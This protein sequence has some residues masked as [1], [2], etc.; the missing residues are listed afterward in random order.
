MGSLGAQLPHRCLESVLH[1]WHLDAQLAGSRGL[2]L[3][4]QARAPQGGLRSQGTFH[5]SPS[6][7][8][9][10]AP[11]P[12]APV[13]PEAAVQQTD[14]YLPGDGNPCCRLSHGRGGKAHLLIFSLLIGWGFAD[15]G[16]APCSS[17]ML[18]LLSTRAGNWFIS[19]AGTSA[20]SDRPQ[21]CCCVS[22][23]FDCLSYGA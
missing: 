16:T 22:I 12:G 3:D 8:S 18:L 7:C 9:A 1:Q 11:L 21:T 6:H 23:I 10:H 15:Q 13:R 4:D 17:L 2:G 14:T 19:Q 5:P 20:P